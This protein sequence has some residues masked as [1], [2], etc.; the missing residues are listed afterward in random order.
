[1]KINGGGF[2]LK[3]K[4]FTDKLKKGS[5]VIKNQVKKRFLLDITSS[6]LL[7]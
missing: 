4:K 1:M 7:I 6:F 3:K 5:V 2:G